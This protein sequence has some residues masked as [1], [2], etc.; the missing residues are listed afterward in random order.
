MFL[1]GFFFQ[2]S[3]ALPEVSLWRHWLPDAAE[4]RLARQESYARH[5]VRMQ[6][7]HATFTG[8][9]SVSKDLCNSLL[10]WMQ[11]MILKL[12]WTEESRADPH[13]P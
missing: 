5:I 9:T 3:L 2:V 6:L 1:G 12:E 4:P 7:K 10:K 11:C 8:A 13:P